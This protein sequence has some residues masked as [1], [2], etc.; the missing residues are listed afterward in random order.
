MTAPCPARQQGTL[1]K[2]CRV[3]GNQLGQVAFQLRGR[4]GVPQME[5]T[6][7][8]EEMGSDLRLRCHCL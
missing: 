1:G 5:P 6:E 3:T 4:L 8:K 7:Q 2:G